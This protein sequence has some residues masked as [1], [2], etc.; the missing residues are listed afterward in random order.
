M[1]IALAMA[2]HETGTVNPSLTTMADFEALGI[3]CGQEM[4]GALKGVGSIGGFL[5]V[6]SK[7]AIVAFTRALAREVDPSG[8]RVTAVAPSAVRTEEE[9]E[10]NVGPMAIAWP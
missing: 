10:S 5:E 8:V 9:T 6:A 7:A 4:L 1:R 2:S 3:R